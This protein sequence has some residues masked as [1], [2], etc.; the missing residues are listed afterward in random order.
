MIEVQLES[1]TVRFLADGAAIDPAEGMAQ[2]FGRFELIGRLPAIRSPGPEVL[3]Y[4]P[5]ALG[6][7]W[8][9]GLPPYVW[10]EA[11]PGLWLSHNG[12]NLL[13]APTDPL[14]AQNL[15]A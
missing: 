4:R 13:L 6:R 8:S 14:M 5:P 7:T 15:G 3:I 1:D 12:E 10:L 11:Q 9:E 2:L